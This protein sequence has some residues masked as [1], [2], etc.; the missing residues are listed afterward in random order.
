MS[1]TAR[2]ISTTFFGR[3][4]EHARRGGHIVPTGKRW[5]KPVSEVEMDRLTQS[6]VELSVRFGRHLGAVFVSQDAIEWLVLVGFEVDTTPFTDGLEE[7]DL[8]VGHALL[9]LHMLQTLPTASSA[10]A[11]NQIA[12]ASNEDDNYTGHAYDNLSTLMP[13]VRTLRLEGPASNVG[14]RWAALTDVCA[15]ECLV[16]DSWMQEGLI[17]EIRLLT[18]NPIDKF[19][20]DSLCR[21]LFDLDPRSLFTSLYRC[22]EAM[23]A[24][25][26]AEALKQELGTA[27]AWYDL[28]DKL[29]STLGWHP[30][31][32][33]GLKEVLAHPSVQE[34][35]VQALGDALKCPAGA[36]SEAVAAAVRKLRNG[37]V[38]YGPVVTS[39]S[40]EAYDW[41]AVCEPMARIVGSLFREVYSKFPVVDSVDNSAP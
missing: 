22:L 23:Y 30:R 38:H 20:Y 12:S 25:E 19:P 11:Y 41:N 39:V 27:V 32:D 5:V 36:T 28:A 21:S 15:Q 8:S 16:R 17:R 29:S 33:T 2:D 1:R 4:E 35:D 13:L 37:V 26:K 10:D 40:I 18:A 34:L 3:L 7:D 24:Y 6:V 31:H 14:A 9:A